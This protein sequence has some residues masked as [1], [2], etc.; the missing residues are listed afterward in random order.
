MKHAVF[1]WFPPIL[2]YYVADI[3]SVDYEF[4]TDHV[5]S[6]PQ[7][8]ISDSLDDDNFTLLEYAMPLRNQGW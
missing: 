7:S 5:E 4:D 8:E 2:D 6:C 1:V 3:M